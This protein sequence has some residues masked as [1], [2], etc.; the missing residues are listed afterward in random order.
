MRTTTGGIPISRTGNPLKPGSWEPGR[1]GLL[2][3]LVLKAVLITTATVRGLD[4]LSP[5]E[6]TTTAVETM[7]LAFPLEVWGFMFLA[8]AML[9]FVGLSARIHFAVWLGHGLLAI[10]Y[11]AL[12]VALGGEYVTRPWWDGIRSASGMLLPTTLHALICFRTGWKPAHWL[13]QTEEV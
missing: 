13:G 12:L 3:A 2:D 9:L 4:Y 6:R 5:V 7:Q 11:F 1:I 10:S 8:P